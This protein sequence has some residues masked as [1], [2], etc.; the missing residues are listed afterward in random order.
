[1]DRKI[2]STRIIRYARR[3][4]RAHA[5]PIG[6]GLLVAIFVSLA[7]WAGIFFGLLALIGR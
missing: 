1:M 2:A 5:M 4:S 6:V 3:R 7:L